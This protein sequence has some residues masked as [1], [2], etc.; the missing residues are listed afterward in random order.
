MIRVSK[1]VAFEIRKK[2]PFVDV[3]VARRQKRNHHY[4]TEERDCVY[5]LID[6]FENQRRIETMQKA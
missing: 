1:E 4:Y 2:L 3:Y 5:K 6:D